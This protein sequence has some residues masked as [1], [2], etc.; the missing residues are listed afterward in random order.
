MRRP[1]CF[2]GASTRDSIDE[3][4]ALHVTVLMGH[5]EI[6]RAILEHGRGAREWCQPPRRDGIALAVFYYCTTGHA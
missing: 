2:H 3:V 5:L 1:T 6:A 4:S